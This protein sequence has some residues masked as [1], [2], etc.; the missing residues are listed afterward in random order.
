MMERH[1]ERLT[2]VDVKKLIERGLDSV[3]LPIGTVEAHGPHL[4]LGT[5]IMIPVSITE[6]LA[7]EIDSLIAPPVNYGVTRSLLVY[8]G[9]LTVPSPAFKEYVK[10]I[11]LSLS[12]HGFR[13]TVVI[14]GHGGQMNELK[15]VGMEVWSETGLKTIIFN[16]WIALEQFTK[17]FFKQQGGHG[18]IDETAMITAI[19]ESLVKK[20]YYSEESAAVNTP[21][22]DVYPFQAPIILYKKGEGLPIFDNRK[23]DE[24]SKGVIEKT[25]AMVKDILAKWDKNQTE[26]EK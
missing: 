7:D 14:N 5:D 19:D 1:I 24:Y 26:F 22:I 3:I 13:K 16:W 23:A 25:I 2:Y 8:P 21:G 6:R 11:L 4:P 18:A 17:D 12:K 10:G 20:E 9:S 15:E